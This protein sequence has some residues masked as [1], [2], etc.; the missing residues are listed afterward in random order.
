[1]K[2]LSMLEWAGIIFSVTYVLA[3]IFIVGR[4]IFG[5]ITTENIKEFL[6]I[7]HRKR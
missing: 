4:W 2:Q 5:E 6:K 3:S 7:K 1:M